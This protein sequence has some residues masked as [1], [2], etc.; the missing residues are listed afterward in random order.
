[1]GEIIFRLGL[2]GLVLHR[3]ESGKQQT[4]QDRNDRN[5]N[6]QLDEC[7]GSRVFL[8]CSGIMSRQIALHN[9]LTTFVRPPVIA[10]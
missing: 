8:H 2:P 10:L 5:H 3:T 4:D 7:E 6:K 1:L 9:D